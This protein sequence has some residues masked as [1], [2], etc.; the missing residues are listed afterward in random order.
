MKAGFVFAL[1]RTVF[2]HQQKPVYRICRP[3]LMLR[4]VELDNKQRYDSDDTFGSIYHNIGVGSYPRRGKGTADR[5]YKV[6]D[7]S[8]TEQH[9]LWHGR[10]SEMVPS[11]EDRVGQT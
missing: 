3:K 8:Y 6:Y 4:F 10:E 2:S 1:L 9:R 7:L 5:F 11:T